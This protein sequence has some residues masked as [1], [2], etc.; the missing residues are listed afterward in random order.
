LF[1]QVQNVH[2]GR[3]VGVEFVV[4]VVGVVVVVPVVV[5]G[6]VVGVVVVVAVVVVVTVGVDVDR[7]IIAVAGAS[8]TDVA[9]APLCVRYVAPSEN[10]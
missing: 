9:E 4:V 1:S 5:V 3:A 2:P 7:R 6:V 8:V 10:V